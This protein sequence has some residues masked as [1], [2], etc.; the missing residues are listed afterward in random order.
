MKK[1]MVFGTFDVLHKGHLF[2]LEQSKKYGDYLIVVLARDCNVIKNK[3]Q[4]LNDEN[5][6]KINIEQLKIV[7]KVIMGK[8]KISFD[9]IIEEKPEIICIGYDQ[10]SRKIE[11]LFPNI[12]FILI[13]SYKPDK[14]KSSLL[15]Q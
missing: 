10:N 13:P 1:V 8:E 7:D 4:P 14:Y 9:M 12:K 15:R 11:Q 3:G 5:K 2:F 6:R